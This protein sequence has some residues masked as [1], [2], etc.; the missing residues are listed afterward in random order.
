VKLS[1]IRKEIDLEALKIFIDIYFKCEMRYFRETPSIFV[2]YIMRPKE[3]K[4]ISEI[5]KYK[6]IYQD[7]IYSFG[8]IEN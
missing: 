4:F 5:W 8:K 6:I 7:S 1:V 2:A 3:R